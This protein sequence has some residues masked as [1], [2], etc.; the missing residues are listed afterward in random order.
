MHD[1]ERNENYQKLREL[2]LLNLI[3][4]CTT[5]RIKAVLTKDEADE[6]NWL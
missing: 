5:C 6:V 3:N 4:S 2:M 1:V